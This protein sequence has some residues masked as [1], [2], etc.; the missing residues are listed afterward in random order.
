M[1]KWFWV[2][3][4]GLGLAV[5]GT[6]FFLRRPSPQKTS[7]NTPTQPPSAP[8]ATLERV[9]AK[10]TSNVESN[11]AAAGLPVQ[12]QA[13]VTSA[14]ATVTKSMPAQIAPTTPKPVAGP[15]DFDEPSPQAVI[16]NMRGSFRD[17]QS[18]FGGNPVGTNPEITKSLNGDNP[19]H[20]T[21]IHP[22]DGLRINDRGELIDPW[23]TP[24]FFHQLSAREMEIHSAGPDRVMWTADDLVTR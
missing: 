22:E 1:T 2:A 9:E 24:F 5:V 11:R 10:R 19:R 15:P 4:L 20:A 18:M 16:E 13:N 12:T 8:T 17:Y 7:S 3:A 21:F 23:G 14:T 6:V